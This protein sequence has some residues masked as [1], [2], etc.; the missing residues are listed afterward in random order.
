[1]C[2]G[3]FVG[4]GKEREGNRIDKKK[5]ISGL[6]WNGSKQLQIGGTNH[7]E[8]GAVSPSVRDDAPSSPC[9]VSNV[10]AFFFFL[11]IIIIIILFLHI[12]FLTRKYLPPQFQGL[13]F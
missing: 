13:S 8:N 3:W 11:I 2:D 9:R 6:G 5:N 1:M 4:E 7:T 10:V 12:Y